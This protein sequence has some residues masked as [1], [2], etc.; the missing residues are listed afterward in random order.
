MTMTNDDGRLGCDGVD[1]ERR[2]SVYCEI[3]RNVRLDE[4][5]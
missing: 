2:E 1:V 5:V 3:G 4:M